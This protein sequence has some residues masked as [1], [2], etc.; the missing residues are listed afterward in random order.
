MVET[1]GT[2]P[3]RP[4][5]WSSSDIDD[6]KRVG[7][8]GGQWSKGST[9]SIDHRFLRRLVVPGREAMAV[10]RRTA[11]SSRLTLRKRPIACFFILVIPTGLEFLF[12]LFLVLLLLLLLEKGAKEKG[13]R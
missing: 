1:D 2:A 4:W 10:D 9:V 13:Q 11:A 6:N 5:N 7:G 8:G 12:F 3:R